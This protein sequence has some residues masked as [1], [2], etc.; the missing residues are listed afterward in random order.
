MTSTFCIRQ[1]KNAHVDLSGLLW[2]IPLTQSVI[3]V[4][5]KILKKV[6]AFLSE[7]LLF[8]VTLQ[9]CFNRTLRH[10]EKYTR[11]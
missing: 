5:Y 9:M 6:P 1:E 4:E 11:S 7:H 3:S 2:S 8:T 10:P